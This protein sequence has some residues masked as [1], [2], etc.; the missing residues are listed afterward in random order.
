MLAVLCS[1]KVTDVG[2]RHRLVKQ[3]LASLLIFFLF[4]RADLLA[5]FAAVV[6]RPAIFYQGKWYR[7]QRRTTQTYR[8]ARRVYLGA[9]TPVRLTYCRAIRR[10][11]D[12]TLTTS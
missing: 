10:D 9:R 6:P 1:T 5:S 12:Q 7:R 4:F 3:D 8:V 2:I 11:T